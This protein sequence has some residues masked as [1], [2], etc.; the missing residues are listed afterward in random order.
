MFAAD[1]MSHGHA[2][3]GDVFFAGDERV[4]SWSEDKNKGNGPSA[5]RPT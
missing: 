1:S 4:S 2:R 5:M 3:V